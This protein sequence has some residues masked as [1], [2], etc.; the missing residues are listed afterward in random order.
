MKQN[1]QDMPLECPTFIPTP[2]IAC[3][4]TKTIPIKWQV[5]EWKLYRD[6]YLYANVLYLSKDTMKVKT[7]TPKG[8][9]GRIQ[10]FGGN[11]GGLIFEFET[12]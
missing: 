6:S 12:Q 2:E 3:K 1:K 11:F 10:T 8:K 7:I 4:E 9:G 5:K